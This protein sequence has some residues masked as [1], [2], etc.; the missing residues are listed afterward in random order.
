MKRPRFSVGDASLVCNVGKCSVSIIAIQ[1]IA[2]ILSH[3]KIRKA[4]VIEIPPHTPEPVSGSGHPGF[5]RDISKCAVTVVAIQRIADGN[6]S[7]IEIAS[8]DEINILPAVAIEIADADSRT[9][10]LAINRDALI[11]FE[12]H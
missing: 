9:K 8:I 12:V 1:N 2:A 7:I 10:F 3:K 11:A 4:V 6:T 5:F